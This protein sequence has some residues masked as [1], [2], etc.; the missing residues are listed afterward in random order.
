MAEE[1]RR[2]GMFIAREIQMRF[3]PQRGGMSGGGHS[4]S[5]LQIVPKPTTPPPYVVN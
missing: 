4:Q 3:E 5:R 1:R 2:R